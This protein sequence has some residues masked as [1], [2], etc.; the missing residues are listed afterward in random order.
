MPNLRSH[1]RRGVVALLLCAALC[2][3][4]QEPAPAPGA[5]TVD[6]AQ[7]QLEFADG[8]FNRAFYAE[9]AQEY[10]KLIEQYPGTAQAATAY[11]RWA[12]AAYATQAY[13]QALTAVN[14]F[15]ATNPEGAALQR[16]QV[17]K[18]EV[19]YQLG[20]HAEAL[21]MLA[22]LVDAGLDAKLR[23]RVLYHAALA[24]RAT[25]D[26]GKARARLEIIGADYQDSPLAPYARYQLG[27][28]LQESGDLEG[29]AAAL[30]SAAEAAGPEDL[31]QEA[32]FRSGEIYDQLG[33]FSA[34]AGAYQKLREAWPD[35]PYATRAWYGLAWAQYHDGKYGEA[36]AAAD[37]WLA[38][39]ASAPEAAAMH[40]LRANCLQQTNKLPEALAAYQ[41]V[42]G[43]AESP[44]AAIS[45]YKIAWVQ[46]LQGDSAG[47]Q[48]SVNA[49][50]QQHPD[51]PEVGN[52]AFLLGLLQ[53][54]QGD[55]E[56]AQQQF[57]RVATQ[58]P[59]SNFAPEAQY[60]AAEC[61]QQLGSGAAAGD[62]FEAFAAAQPEHP[63]A[64]DARLRAAEARFAAQQ[65]D[66]SVALY[67]A[68]ME[69]GLDGAVAAE[70]RYRIALALY[71][72]GDA[73]GAGAAFAELVAKDAKSPYLA[74]AH[75]R[76]G[77][78]ALAVEKDPVKALSAFQAALEAAP[79]GPF[80][81]QALR[82]AA[83]ARYESKDYDAAAAAFLD[84]T[85]RFPQHPLQEEAYV[86]AGEYL[87]EKQ[88]W[89]DAIAVFEA[90]LK[91]LPAYPNPERVLLKIAEASEHA[92]AAAD[93]LPRLQAVVD[94]APASSLAAEARFR[95]AKLHEAQ[96][97]P[98]QAI[99]L[100][101]AAADANTGDVAARAR[102]RLAEL[103][104]AEGRH[105]DAARHF[106]RVA[107]LYLH[108]E[109]SP[110]ALLR[111][112]KAY[113]AAEKPGQAKKAYEELVRDFAESPA[114]AQARE[115]LARLNGA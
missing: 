73:A 18:G 13:E 6:P 87:F 61:L 42:Q 36:L 98:G 39:N 40:Y 114:A 75:F 5:E 97:Q 91:A 102:F 57:Q 90:M 63:L 43:F 83:I 66:K 68:A 67:R 55:Y 16:A 31:R 8:L 110:E 79:E 101:E 17:I 105:E 100:Y 26:L 112:G 14:A 32:R 41:Q 4:A 3:A 107:I 24:A 96:E 103:L 50:L 21:E 113:E 88:Q 86:W 12:E 80:A 104:E 28:V 45:Q 74:E 52:A 69:A 23:A 54:A 37:A 46:Y 59:Q 76:L 34:A 10:H 33:W 72:A 35:S 27:F 82:G 9:A 70:V 84:V 48:Q 85:R 99:A 30:T 89:A 56:N 111:A 51:S 65:Y 47:A 95:M 1:S 7:A 71:N 58:Y 78:H 115:S 53:T 109:L 19:L 108:Q 22:P 2:A 64:K 92:G 29:A 93:V 77:E 94:A 11:Q 20:R 49:F 44:F 62:A 106:M 60:R 25:G 15:L 81:P 38:A